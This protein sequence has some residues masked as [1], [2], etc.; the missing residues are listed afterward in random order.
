MFLRYMF[1]C[2]IA[3]VLVSA[4]PVSVP[5]ADTCNMFFEELGQHDPP[6]YMYECLGGCDAGSCNMV[7]FSSGPYTTSLCNCGSSRTQAPC[8]A[9]VEN[10]SGTVTW[11]CLASNCAT[12]CANGSGTSGLVCFCN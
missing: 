6:V 10:L 4:A 3:S 11:E 5:P 2:L 9:S 1:V 12:S 8:P 7:T